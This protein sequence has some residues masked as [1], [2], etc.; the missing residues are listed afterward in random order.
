MEL[1]KWKITKLFTS[2][3]FKGKTHTSTGTVHMPV[4]FKVK[5][6]AAGSSGYVIIEC[7]EVA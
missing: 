7:V 5:K 1:K 6:P 3:L 4:G 2:G